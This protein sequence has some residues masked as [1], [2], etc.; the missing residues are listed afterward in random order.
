MYSPPISAP[1]L[2]SW[3]NAV[4]PG[5]DSGVITPK[6]TGSCAQAWLSPKRTDSSRAPPANPPRRMALLLASN[7]RHV[8]QAGIASADTGPILP[9][10]APPCRGRASGRPC[11]EPFAQLAERLAHRLEVVD[12]EARS[13]RWA[14]RAQPFL[15]PPRK[16]SATARAD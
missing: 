6:T 5:G 16:F 14:H 8:A 4:S 3:P 10:R 2:A 7:A 13:Q 9:W 15:E 1:R 11:Q 12:M